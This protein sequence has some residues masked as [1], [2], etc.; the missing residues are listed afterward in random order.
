MG[1]EPKNPERG[2]HRRESMS[3]A[4]AFARSYF[5]HPGPKLI[6]LIL[7][8]RGS[9]HVVG[10]PMLGLGRHSFWG[11]IKNSHPRFTP[12]FLRPND[13]N[14]DQNCRISPSGT[15]NAEPLNATET[16]NDDLIPSPMSRVTGIFR[17][18]IRSS[19]GGNGAAFSGPEKNAKK[20]LKIS[21]QYE[22]G[23]GLLADNPCRNPPIYFREAPRFPHKSVAP[24]S[25]KNPHFPLGSRRVDPSV[26]IPVPSPV[27][28][29]ES[30]HCLIFSRS[31]STLRN[32]PQT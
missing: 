21:C 2:N 32:L 20:L 25:R 31:I 26:I 22:G 7:I 15:G 9:I 29:P 27:P 5:Y 11:L 14:C 13:G 12:T 24:P 4:R 8:P 10:V 19:P 23:R 17:P 16:G 6:S 18:R 3:S 1:P 28:S 30:H